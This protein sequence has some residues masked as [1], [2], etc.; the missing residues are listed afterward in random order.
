[1]KREEQGRKRRSTAKPMVFSPL[2]FS[3]NRLPSVSAWPQ[4][5]SANRRQIHPRVVSVHW[6][7]LGGGFERL[8]RYHFVSVI[9]SH[10]G[11]P[12]KVIFSILWLLENDVLWMM[13][14]YSSVR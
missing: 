10:A 6:T 7:T 12:A 8:D 11:K 3:S 9:L 5:R 13:A 14:A 2:H 1:M 4:L